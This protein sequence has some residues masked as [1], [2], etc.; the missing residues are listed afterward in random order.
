MDRTDYIQKAQDLLNNK[1][2]YTLQDINLTNNITKVINQFLISVQ[3]KIPEDIY[4]F[5]RIKHTRTPVFYILPKIHKIDIPG[6]PIVSAIGGPTEKISATV[7]Y[8]LKPL[9]QLVPSY[10]KDTNDFLLK[11]ENLGK[12]PTDSLLVT[13]DVSSLYTS[14]PHR[15]GILAA[16][17]ALD[18]NNQSSPP[19]W[20]LLRFLHLVLTKN[21]F[22]FDGKFYL[23]T[24]GTSMGTK[25]APNY[26]II[27]MD[28]L[29]QK[30]LN[31]QTIKPMVWW[32]YVDDIFIIW[33]H[34]RDAL[35]GVH[36]SSK[37][38]SQN[39][40]VH[41]RNQRH[42]DKLPGHYGNKTS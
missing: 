31:Q 32:R 38:I 41:L 9:A 37:P 15:D 36:G 21:C 13:A 25:C 6:R 5:N 8:Y 14:I 29:E 12:I 28:Q 42:Q 30:F 17:E 1:N 19:T 40:K 4:Q 33:T 11:L 10:I 18:A 7:D 34:H 24:Q 22:E 27:F 23:Q 39:H 35:S 16:K 26:A 2:H 3:A 20:I